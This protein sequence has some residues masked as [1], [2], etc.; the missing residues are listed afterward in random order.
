ME[1]VIIQSSDTKMLENIPDVS[2]Y[3]G[4]GAYHSW[5]VN[6]VII[7]CWSKPIKKKHAAYLEDIKMYDSVANM[8]VTTYAGSP[9]VDEFVR[10]CL[11]VNSDPVRHCRLNLLTPSREPD[12]ATL[13]RAHLL[14]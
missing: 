3:Y 9:A 6:T 2:N 7:A 4:P 14:I 8:G 5:L 13:V 11:R 1:G 10:V 12:S